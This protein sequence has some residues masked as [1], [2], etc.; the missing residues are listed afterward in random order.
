[1]RKIEIKSS[2]NDEL[3]I[4]IT[5]YSAD[6]GVDLSF[7]GQEVEISAEDIPEIIA[8]LQRASEIRAKMFA[9]NIAQGDGQ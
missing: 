5:A 6:D 3:E 7:Y 1:M 8:L 2:E 9:D 4:G